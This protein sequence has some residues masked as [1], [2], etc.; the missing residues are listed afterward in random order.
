M[1]QEAFSSVLLRLTGGGYAGKIAAVSYI[2]IPTLSLAP[3]QLATIQWQH[4]YS[5]GAHTAPLIAS[6]A[7]VCWAYLAIKARLYRGISNG[8]LGFYTTAAITV[9]SIIPFT[10]AAIVPTNNKLDHLATLSK[11]SSP[12][13]DVK[14]KSP[15]VEG[16]LQ[17]WKKLNMTRALL[18]GSSFLAGVWGV[19]NW[20]GMDIWAA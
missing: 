6:G 17:K 14:V 12:T 11:S 4:M 1:I 7:A 3:P 8:P 16:L 18:T 2:T 9:I 15:E 13:A 20:P 10:L 5:N 19:L